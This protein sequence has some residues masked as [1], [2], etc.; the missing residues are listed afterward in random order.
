MSNY[1]T[2]SKNILI[3]MSG[4][5]A[6][7]KICSL[8]SKLSQNNFNVKV[9]M[10]AAA[11]KFVGTATIEGLSHNAV[12]TE[13]FEM[14]QA[15]EHIYLDRWADLILL[16]PASANSINKIANGFGDDLISTLFLAHD[17]KKPFL[18]APAMNTN[19]YMHPTTQKSISIL[20]N[21]G[22]EILETASGVLACGE[23]GYGRLLEPDL[24]Y[25]EIVSKL[26]FKIGDENSKIDSVKNKSLKI[27]VTAGG[28]QVPIDDVRCI[29][30][31][32]TGKTAATLSDQFINAGFEVTYLC[33]QN[34]IR[35]NFDCTIETFIT[36]NDLDLKLTK[37]LNNKFDIVIHTAAVSDYSVVNSQPGKINSSNELLQINLIKNPKLIY[38]IKTFSP[39]SLLV[40]FK[41]TSKIGELEIQNKI[42]SLFEN[43]KCDL[44]VQNDWQTVHTDKH[45]FNIYS[46]KLVTK[47]LSVFD[48]SYALIESFMTK[49][50][51]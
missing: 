1:K 9:V 46:K 11:Q 4:S 45:I 13:T 6:C 7:Y 36:Y 28:T 42:D 27:L 15:M 32:S 21:I 19:M 41:L 22:V 17:F 43:A 14:G 20:K 49:E 16:A 26:E 3:L 38:K 34:S 12:H 24:L 44:V 50:S 40:G 39:E 23:T 8:I 5:I 51:L 10:S 37:L 47:N 30:N 35:P 2:T 18:V 31:N 33:A 29:T 48:L 25:A